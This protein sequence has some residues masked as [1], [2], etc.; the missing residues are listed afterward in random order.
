M[1]VEQFNYSDSV[2]RVEESG[3]KVG[4]QPDSSLG[5]HECILLLAEASTPAHFI[6]R[7]PSLSPS[8]SFIPENYFLR[9]DKL[10]ESGE[11]NQSKFSRFFSVLAVSEAILTESGTSVATL[12]QVEET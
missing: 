1:S 9:F 8:S 3:R 7:S 4:N 11:K 5:K 6:T 10:R 12:F 2:R